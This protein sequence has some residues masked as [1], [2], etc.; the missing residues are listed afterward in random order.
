MWAFPCEEEEY[1]KDIFLK[2]PKLKNC[3]IVVSFRKFSSGMREELWGRLELLYFSEE[4]KQNMIVAT[5]I[6]PGTPHCV[7][8]F[9]VRMP[10]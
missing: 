8:M 1:E 9:L 5:K 7:G 2:L 3:C 4:E 10:V 6:H